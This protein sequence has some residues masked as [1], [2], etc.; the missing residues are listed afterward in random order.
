MAGHQDK[1]CLGPHHIW[2]IPSRACRVG[3]SPHPEISVHVGG[4]CRN[5]SLVST[6]WI[7]YSSLHKLLPFTFKKIILRRLKNLTLN[8]DQIDL[9]TSY[10]CSNFSL[11]KFGG[12]LLLCTWTFMDL[13]QIPN[14]QQ[15]RE[16]ALIKFLQV[17][18]WLPVR[19]EWLKQVDGI[20]QQF[21]NGIRNLS[22]QR[23]LGCPCWVHFFS[24]EI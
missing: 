16:G 14:K 6:C 10:N 12:L 18:L 13:W 19:T 3:R 5:P 20:V 17:D 8:R 4:Y 2:V 24:S 15:L 7:F 11:Y 23:H 9:G 21:R 22:H 1:L